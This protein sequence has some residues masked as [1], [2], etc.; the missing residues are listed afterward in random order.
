MK[1][2]Y[3]FAIGGFLAIIASGLVHGWWT[4]R[5][6]I[7]EE[8]TAA[9]ARLDQVPLTIGEWDGERLAATPGSIQRRYTHRTTGTAVTVYLVCGRPGPISIHTPDACYGAGGYEVEPP[10]NFTLPDDAAPAP[11]TFPVARMTRR[12][13]TDQSRLRV[14]WSWSTAGAWSVPDNPRGA[15]AGQPVLYKM[16]LIRE[17]PAVEEPPLEKDPCVELLRGLVPVLQRTL[18]AS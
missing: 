12:R 15:F 5:W 3:G 16:Y 7:A 1:P 10:V 2:S 14:F 18:F 6:G 13:A 4:D 9:A 11:G 8:P 17:L